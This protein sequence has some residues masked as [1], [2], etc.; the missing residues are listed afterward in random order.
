MGKGVAFPSLQVSVGV[1]QRAVSAV[2]AGA[3]HMVVDIVFDIL[4]AIQLRFHDAILDQIEGKAKLIGTGLQKGN[5]RIGLEHPRL[6][7]VLIDELDGG[8]RLAAV[9]GIDLALPTHN[10]PT[11]G[12]IHAVDDGR[13]NAVNGELMRQFIAHLGTEIVRI[14]FSSIRGGQCAHM[15]AYCHQRVSET[16]M[17]LL[18]LLMPSWTIH[19]MMPGKFFNQHLAIHTADIQVGERHRH[20]LISRRHQ[21]GTFDFVTTE[22]QYSG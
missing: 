21:I 6:R 18:Q 14:A 10:R 3:Q 22:E 17:Q 9:N 7:I 15:D 4:C 1:E 2:Q 5:L 20:L 8:Q 11:A 12:F 13:R 16:L 19:A